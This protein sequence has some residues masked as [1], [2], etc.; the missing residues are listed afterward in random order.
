MPRT[1]WRQS[2]LWLRAWTRTE[3]SRRRPRTWTGAAAGIEWSAGDGRRQ[4]G[5]T[6]L[7]LALPDEREA[8]L[9]EDGL[10]GDLAPVVGQGHER[11]VRSLGRELPHPLPTRRRGVGR[12]GL[13]REQ[14]VVRVAG[15][16]VVGL[17]LATHVVAGHVH[18]EHVAD[19]LD[20]LGLLVGPD[21][22]RPVELDVPLRVAEH[23]EDLGCRGVDGALDGDLSVVAHEGALPDRRAPA[24]GQG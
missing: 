9:R 19:L 23:V 7:E 4:C 5:E 11:G 16:G 1:G 15:D 13:P 2:S 22:A 14:R 18:P 8:H 24:T 17:V 10:V 6:V 3:T 12:R 20:A 21:E